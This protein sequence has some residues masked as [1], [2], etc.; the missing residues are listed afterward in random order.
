MLTQ[1]FDGDDKLAMLMTRYEKEQQEFENHW[2]WRE[3]KTTPREF[4][5]KIDAY[6]KTSGIDPRLWQEKLAEAKQGVLV[7]L[8][9]R[10]RQYTPTNFKQHHGLKA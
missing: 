2:L 7:R 5:A 6:V 3:L 9:E 10:S 4:F 8:R 1:E